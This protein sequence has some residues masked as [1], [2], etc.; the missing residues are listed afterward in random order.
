MFKWIK[1]GSTTFKTNTT[2]I[3]L[4]C[5][6]GLHQFGRIVST[7]HLQ[8][9]FIFV[10]QMLETM[11][12]DEHLQSFRVRKRRDEFHMAVFVDDLTSF[13]VYIS[14]FPSL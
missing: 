9:R 7:V 11:L 5:Q 6:S 14:H 10:C 13:N 8:E 1:I 2:V 4:K 3:L 12:F